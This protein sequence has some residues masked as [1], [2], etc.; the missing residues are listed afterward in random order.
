MSRRDLGSLFDEEGQGATPAPSEAP[1]KSPVDDQLLNDEAVQML[2]ERSRGA[3]EAT[4]R[5]A[6]VAAQKGKELGKAA[7]GALGRMKEEHKRR[8]QARA[9]AMAATQAAIV[10]LEDSSP[11]VV[12]SVRG[13]DVT[14]AAPM[15]VSVLSAAFEVEA[16]Q[17]ILDDLRESVEGF[18]EPE[19]AYEQVVIEQVI[20]RRADPSAPA[21]VQMPARKRSYTRVWITGG[22]LVLAAFGGGAYWWSTRPDSATAA[23][24]KSDIPAVKPVQPGPSPVVEA[25]P[26]PVEEIALIPAP[27][28]QVSA[29][30]AVEKAEP[31]A[32]PEP[33]PAAV[34]DAPKTAPKP[35]AAPRPK[36]NNPEPASIPMPPAKEE[37]QIDQIRD[38]GKQLEQLG[39]R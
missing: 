22:V 19:P 7:L 5:A 39:E 8:S 31:V 38:F 18:I 25:L 27:V 3:R 32:A 23:P 33:G 1:R 16:P 21:Q 17:A 13:E 11:D 37:Q 20:Q 36:P 6:E 15:S 10:P 24:P 34:V 30:P 29:P 4:A 9:E 28:Q 26:A 12:E 35:I 2:E 14:M